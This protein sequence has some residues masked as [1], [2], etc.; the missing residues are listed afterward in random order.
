MFGSHCLYGKGPC[1]YEEIVRIPFIVRWP[2]MSPVGA[3]SKE[4][5]SHI[6]LVPT[7]LEYFGLPI[8]GILQG[9]SMLAQ[10]RDPHHRT[11]IAEIADAGGRGEVADGP[12][13]VFE[14]DFG[15]C[16]GVSA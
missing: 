13:V 1:M 10:M 5:V 3:V 14:E 8:P 7:L 2:T 16:V 6:D 9:R 12:A 15:P 4:P 11:D